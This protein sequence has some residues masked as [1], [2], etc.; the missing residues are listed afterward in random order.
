[1]LAVPD[2]SLELATPTP[3]AQIDITYDRFNGGDQPFEQIIDYF[4]FDPR[5]TEP[6]NTDICEV[7]V[8]QVVEETHGKTFLKL[9]TADFY[10]IKLTIDPADVVWLE[11]GVWGDEGD[12]VFKLQI[13]DLV[14]LDLGQQVFIEFNVHIVADYCSQV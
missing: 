11:G 12:Y 10:A 2:C 8:Y 5:I 14:F 3:V 13:M 4:V 7:S 1:M 6:F 9:D